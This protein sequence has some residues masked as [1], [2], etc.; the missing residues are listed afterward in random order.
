MGSDGAP[1]GQ[2]PRWCERSQPL[3]GAISAR[4]K[5]ATGTSLLNRR[6]HTGPG[7]RGQL[8]HTWELKVS[9]EAPGD[10]LVGSRDYGDLP[11]QLIR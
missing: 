7:Q 11:P 3:T 4:R 1:S 6:F 10:Q 5:T 9:W 2:S 8:S